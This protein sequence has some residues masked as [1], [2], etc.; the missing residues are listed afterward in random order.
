M[1]ILTVFVEELG[2]VTTIVLVEI[3]VFVPDLRRDWEE[4][5]ESGFTDDSGPD[6]KV[7]VGVGVTVILTVEELGIVTTSVFV[8]IMVFVPDLRREREGVPSSGFTCVVLGGLTL[9]FVEDVDTVLVFVGLSRSFHGMPGKPS[10][11]SN[12]AAGGMV[13][14]RSTRRVERVRD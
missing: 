7:G 11:I 12:V 2:I 9:K 4:V 13:W 14:L 3:M 5:L 10:G 8:E 1:V 6:P